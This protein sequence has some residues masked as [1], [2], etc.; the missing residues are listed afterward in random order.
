MSARTK[1]CRAEIGAC[2]KSDTS[3]QKQ[4]ADLYVFWLI[5]HNVDNPI[6]IPAGAVP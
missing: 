6:H 1:A 4:T 5:K 3:G 2:V